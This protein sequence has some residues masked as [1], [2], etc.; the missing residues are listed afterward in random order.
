MSFKTGGPVCC[1]II[2]NVANI[3]I[4]SGQTKHHSKQVWISGEAVNVLTF[5]SFLLLK[6]AIKFLLV[7]LRQ[8][9]QPHEKTIQYKIL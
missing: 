1:G 6:T 8:Q 5:R 2:P 7:I 9:N 4:I 3:Q